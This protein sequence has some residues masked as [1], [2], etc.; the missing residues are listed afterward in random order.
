M[1]TTHSTVLRIK[2]ISN[3]G[4]EIW[5]PDHWFAHSIEKDDGVFEISLHRRGPAVHY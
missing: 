3:T 4:S 1:A 2:D 5:G